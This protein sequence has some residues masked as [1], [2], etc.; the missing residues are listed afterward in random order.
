MSLANWFGRWPALGQH[1]PTTI[2][3]TALQA[4]ST[5]PISEVPFMRKPVTVAVSTR[6]MP[7]RKT[8]RP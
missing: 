4:P 6:A 1:A 7:P 2:A 8:G 5:T 3:E